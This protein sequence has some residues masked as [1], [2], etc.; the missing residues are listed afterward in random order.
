MVKTMCLYLKKNVW[1]YKQ[2]NAVTTARGL[3]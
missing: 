2:Y 1:S 3:M